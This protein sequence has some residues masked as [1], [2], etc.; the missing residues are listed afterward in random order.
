MKSMVVLLKYFFN[1][2][3][4]M[5]RPRIIFQFIKDHLTIM[6]SVFVRVFFLR[7]KAILLQFKNQK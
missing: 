5:L 2:F 6:K 3:M 4:K 7:E 1:Q